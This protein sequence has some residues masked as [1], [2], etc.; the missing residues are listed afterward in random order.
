MQ[1]S[2]LR[3]FKKRLSVQSIN[4]LSNNICDLNRGV[5]ITIKAEMSSGEIQL[6]EK[7]FI[8]RRTLRRDH[9]IVYGQVQALFTDWLNHDR[10]KIKEI[11]VIL[12]DGCASISPADIG[13][14]PVRNKAPLLVAFLESNNDLEMTQ[15]IIH[16]MRRRQINNR[17]VAANSVC[18]LK[19][20]TVRKLKI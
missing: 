13:I 16:S 7:R 3:V 14:K 9:W 2:E 1:S 20:F 15:Q 17:D 6:I 19:N 11:Q 12:Q 5:N 10:H 4:S 8:S 18:G